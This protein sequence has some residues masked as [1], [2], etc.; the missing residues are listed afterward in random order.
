MMKNKTK[1]AEV[2]IAKAEIEKAFKELEAE[3]KIAWNGEWR[4]N[5]NGKLQKVYVAVEFII[6]N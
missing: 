6:K 2:D 4:K 1:M 3:G 5:G